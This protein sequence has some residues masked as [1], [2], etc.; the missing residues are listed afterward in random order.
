MITKGT[1]GVKCVC[2][3]V[4]VF[5]RAYVAVRSQDLVLKV[6]KNH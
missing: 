6:M 4:C 1:Q 5:V 3:C 2:M